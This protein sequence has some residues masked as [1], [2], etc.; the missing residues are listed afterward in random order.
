[1][2]QQAAELFHA[3][4]L[5]TIA[6][7]FHGAPEPK[8]E[9]FNFVHGWIVIGGKSFSREDCFGPRPTLDW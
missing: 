9:D 6:H 3:H 2:K 7:L 4:D 5:A 8:A 1:M